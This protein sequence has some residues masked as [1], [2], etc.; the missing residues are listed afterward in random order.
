MSDAAPLV[1]IFKALG[2]ESRVRIVRL[3]RERPLCVNALAARLGVT[4][5]AVSQHLRL[6]ASAGLVR[7]RRHGYYVHYEINPATLRR[8]RKLV[9]GL[10]APCGQRGAHYVQRGQGL[11]RAK[12]AQGP[13]PGLLGGADPQVPRRCEEAPVCPARERRQ[14][15]SIPASPAGAV[16]SSRLG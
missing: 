15:A 5:A 14:V 9:D 10:L 2:V 6:L 4:P 12:G 1:R 8:W 7:G 16:N 13:P 11:S 3:L